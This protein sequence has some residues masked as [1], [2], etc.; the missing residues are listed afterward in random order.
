MKVSVVKNILEA[1]D[2]IAEENRAIFDEKNLLVFNLM[3]SPGAGKTSLLEKTI[4]ALKD[5]LNIGVIEG[6]IQ[7]SQDAERIAE[8]GIP[9]VQINTGGACHLDGNMIRDTFKEFDFNTL[10]LLVVENVGNLVCP[11]EFK[12]GEDFK[13]MILSVTEGEDKP[14]KYPLMFHES[15]VLL[16]NKIDLLPY[17]DCSV[18]KIREEVLKINPGMV[19]FEVSCK[20]GEGLDAWCK[21]I[22]GEVKTRRS[23]RKQ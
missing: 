16:I 12:V 11:A 5:D 9:A 2:R 4:D 3:S 22:R 15:K 8:K 20:T 7:S 18:E 21:W 13:A 14:A 17:V 6:D 23:M 10:D 1:N 19:I